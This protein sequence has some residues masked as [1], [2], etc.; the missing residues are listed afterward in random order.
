VT[1]K[2]DEVQH[3]ATG[4]LAV[5]AML[6][7]PAFIERKCLASGSIEASAEVTDE[8]AGTTIVSRRVLPA[9]L[10]GF[11]K[12]FVGETLTLVETQKWSHPAPDSG[13]RTA[14]FVVDFGNNPISFGGNVTLRPDGDGTRVEYVGDIKCSVPF[15]GGKIEG[16]AEDWITRYLDKEQRVGTDW[17]AGSQD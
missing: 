14:T 17:L 11:A 5:F 9:K 13:A 1:T 8:D 16:V 2:I 12:K 7:D 6:S 15:V 10:P 4:P 3:Y